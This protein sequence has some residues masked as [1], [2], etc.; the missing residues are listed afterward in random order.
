MEYAND[1]KMDAIMKEAVLEAEILRTPRG[2]PFLQ[3]IPYI[4]FSISHSKTIW[5]CAIGSHPI[6][7]DIEDFPRFNRIG[8][9]DAED[10]EDGKW[11]NMAGRFFTKAE[12]DY[13]LKEGERSF[14]KLWTRKEAYI[15]YKGIGLSDGLAEVELIKDGQPVCQLPDEW[16]DEINVEYKLVAAYCA[17]HKR[18]TKKI[19]DYRK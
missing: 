19:Y 14:L 5:G 11:I 10:K 15:K 6:G 2:K 12:Q 8:G 4:H 3:G 18:E 1:M 13:V 17:E 9:T 7:F 16:V